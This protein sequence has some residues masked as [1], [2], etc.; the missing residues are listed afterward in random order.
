MRQRRSRLP[1]VALLA[2]G[3]LPVTAFA[4]T[5]CST[6]ASK[7]AADAIAAP[8]GV[9]RAAVAGN[10][11]DTDLA[12][13]TSDAIVALKAALVTLVDAQVACAASKSTDTKTLAAALERAAGDGKTGDAAIGVEAR[14]F[15]DPPLLGVTAQIPIPCGVDALWLAYVPDGAHWRRVLTTTSPRYARVDGA[16]SAF[17][18]AVSPRDGDGRWFAAMSHIRPWCTS[19][20]STIDYTV[21]RPGANPDAPAPVFA[22]SDGL[23]WGNDD[24]GRLKVDAGHVELRFT[25]ASIDTGLH[26]REYV[27]RY[28]IDGATATRVAPVAS[29][30]RDFVDEWIVSPWP[31]ARRWSAQASSLEQ[32]HEA[33]H[34]A[35]KRY[36]PVEFGAIAACVDAPGTTQVE[37]RRDDGAASTFFRVSGNGDYVMAAVAE[38]GAPHC[39]TPLPETPAAD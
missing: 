13:A 15:D 22:G 27:R 30:A 6:E 24:T 9:V 18:V 10:D 36:E 11:L 2:C 37:L 8:R 20:W 12:P 35:R 16:W 14:T 4:Q 38:R 3:A 25:G 26:N 31:L 17:Q 32:A 39:D 33:L 7:K 28:A 34:A 21:L 23:W 5:A 29:S 19:T 1:A